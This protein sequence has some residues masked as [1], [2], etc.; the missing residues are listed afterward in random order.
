MLGYGHELR[1]KRRECYTERDRLNTARWGNALEVI[2][3]GS[4]AEGLSRYLESDTDT[5]CINNFVKCIEAGCDINSIPED[6]SVFRMDTTICNPGHCLLL[7]E[8]GLPLVC[9][10]AMCD[11]GHGKILLSSE[12]YV[13]CHKK[14]SHFLRGPIPNERA[15]PS[16]PVTIGCVK[17][18]LVYAFRCHC[19]SILQRWASRSRHWP[20]FNV[21][22]KVVSMGAFVTPVGFKG[23]ES[24]NI[25]WRICFNT[26]ETEL[27][28]NLNDAQIKLYVL[29]KMIGKDVLKPRHKEI[30]SY[31]LKN[32]V[33]WLA[34]KNPQSMFHEKSLLFWLREALLELRIA[35]SNKQLPYYMI[36]ERNLMATELTDTQ[37]R[38]WIAT[39]TDMLGEGPAIIRRL[40]L[41]RQAIIS[42][43]DPFLWY[44]TRR[45]ELEIILLEFIKSAPCLNGNYFAN[46]FNHYF[47]HG[48]MW[49]L[50]VICYDVFLK[51]FVE[52][53]TYTCIEFDCFHILTRMLM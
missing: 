33:L 49:R 32:I 23:S 30:T 22:E 35:L 20:P 25:E 17:H 31:I 27:M 51:M 53:S 10:F 37:K 52:D 6:T 5:V 2:T 43:P 14:M 12:A 44:N 19:P 3:V 34:E 26:G 45:I 18:D 36:P 24:K 41:I 15:G 50:L 28:I 42:Y 48:L 46:M 40:P 39:L 1:Q 21:V 16:L 7:L 13:N 11:N 38:R 8:R 29:L 4:K 9:L 47:R